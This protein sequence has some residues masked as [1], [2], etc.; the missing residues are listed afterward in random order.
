MLNLQIDFSGPVKVSISYGNLTGDV[1]TSGSLSADAQSKL[2]AAATA[3]A[4][5]S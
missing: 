5:S 3:C 1:T 2:T 4:G